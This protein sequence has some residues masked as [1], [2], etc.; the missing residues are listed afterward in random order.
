MTPRIRHILRRAARS[1][2][3]N[4]Y[5]N[6]VAIGVIA[7]TVLLFG[8]YLSVQFNLNRMVDTWDR[9]IHV[10]AYF[11]P[12]VP[13]KRRFDVRDDLAQRTEVHKV[14]YV[15]SEEANQWMRT[16]MPAM[17]TVLE[18]LG[19][20]TLPASL[21]ISLTAN[22]A[23]PASIDDFARTLSVTDF[24]DVDY[25]QEWI[26]KF[27]GFL[28]LLKLLGAIMG[29]LILIAALFLVMNTV[30][31]VVYNRKEEIEIEKLVGA[32]DGYTLAPFLMEGLFQGLIG[33]ILA[34]FGLWTVHQLLVA[35]LKDTFELAVT[36][37]LLFLPTPYIG[38]L[39]AAGSFLGIG[40]SFIAVRRFLSKVT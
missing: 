25:G 39:F 6:S 38:L 34:L 29:S 24:S 16:R 2:W 9:D 22:A 3:E 40:A 19:S 17:E 27:E 18:E 4:A 20:D 8:V 28:S 14:T 26:E 10:S 13:E 21:E 30:H 15:S 11:H 1:L 33:S 7:S 31:L 32:T 23:R 37:E 35:R 36:A 12:D 5:L